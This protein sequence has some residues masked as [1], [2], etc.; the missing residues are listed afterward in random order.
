M[1]RGEGGIRVDCGHHQTSQLC[2]SKVPFFNHLAYEEM[3]KITEIS[4]HRTYEKGEI[5]HQASD[6]LDY[7]YIVHI[8]SVKIYQ[9]FESGK[10]Q[11]LRILETGMFFGELALF[12]EKK[13]E[14][15]AE[16]LEKTNICMIHRDQMQQLMLEHPT[17]AVKILEQF[18][19]RLDDADKLIGELSAK[20]VE[21]R[22]AGYL[23]DLVGQQ[24]TLKLRLPITKK[25]LASLLGTTQETLSRRMTNFQRKGMIEQ[26]G[27][28]KIQIL[29][30][31]ELEKIA[32]SVV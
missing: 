20:D 3:V 26:E 22:I 4:V 25:D 7:L 8:G 31:E 27:H 9:L 2:V 24:Q 28:K 18:S 5:I 1:N 19:Q 21:A 23:L 14:S 6:P 10:E 12:T 11:I 32:S 16:A 15:Y 17:I 30:Q 29:N 13:L